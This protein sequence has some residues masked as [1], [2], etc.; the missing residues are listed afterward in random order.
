M[1]PSPPTPSSAYHEQAL[2]RW[3]SHW[4]GASGSRSPRLMPLR[5]SGWVEE[6][7]VRGWWRGGGLQ[8]GGTGAKGVAISWGG[9]LHWP[10]PC[11]RHLPFCLADG[12]AVKFVGAETFRLCRDLMDGVVLVDNAATSA[13]IK[14]PCCGC[15]WLLGCGL[16]GNAATPLSAPKAPSVTL[17]PR[18]WHAAPSTRPAPS[19]KRLVPWCSG[20]PHG[21]LAAL[22]AHT[23]PSPHQLFLAPL[24]SPQDVFN[25]TRSILEPA[26]AVAVAGA[27][28][29]LQHYG[30]KGQTVVAV[31][32]GANMNFDRLRL[33]A[34]EE[35]AVRVTVS[36]AYRSCAARGAAI[37]CAE[38]LYAQAAPH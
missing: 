24:L 31:T 25:E 16:V 3:R 6:L 5:V 29:Y 18:P 37:A 26:G 9:T 28:A 12:V 4:R 38:P 23:F 30:L 11:T 10:P 33:V 34:G 21:L 27:K 36:G 17:E 13:A 20:G 14:V 1:V 7:Y 8:S 15:M 35:G 2:T 22:R 32:S 19:R